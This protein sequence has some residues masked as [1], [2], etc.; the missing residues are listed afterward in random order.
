MSR[1]RLTKQQDSF[2][3]WYNEVVKLSGLVDDPEKTPGR[4]AMII[5]PEGYAIWERI[6]EALDYRF[7]A[8]GHQNAYFPLLI[9]MSLLDREK[10]HIDG[11][12]PELAVVTHGGGKKLEEPLVIR[13]TSE[14]II[15]EWMSRKVISRRDLPILINQ[16]ANVMRWEKRSRPFLRTTEFLWQE[17]HTAHA[18]FEEAEQETL[19]MLDQYRDFAVNEA[20]LPVICGQKSESE[21]FAG[22]YASYTIEAMMKDLKALQAGTSH[23]LGQN[24]SKVLDIKFT[25]ENNTKQYCWTTS[26]GI[27]TRMIGA[28]VMSHG[29]D[30]G[31]RLPPRLAPIQVIIIPIF[32][33]ENEKETVIEYSETI[34]ARLSKQGIRAKLDMRD[35]RPG[36]KFNDW[37]LRGIPL[38]IEIG[39]RDIKSSSVRL[40]RRDVNNESRSEDISTDNIEHV[41]QT[42]LNDIHDSMLKQATWFRDSNIIEVTSNYQEFCEVV[43]SGQWALSWFTGESNAEQKVKHDTNS[44]T[45]CFPLEQPY[46]NKTGQCIVTGKQA[47]RMALFAKSY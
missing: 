11:F 39:P 9:P 15:G 42:R 22:A 35:E 37:E 27:S 8:T 40:V 36:F 10:E 20:A 46:P 25:D 19:L 45:R 6:R 32:H 41:V 23:N 38:R 7:K 1:H 18:T 5:E 43:R 3:D 30:V 24:F 13:P 47:T 44:V 28:I 34:L 12:S 31:L 16:W 4:G 17:G 29:D 14:M 26:W 33:D 21:K 2:P